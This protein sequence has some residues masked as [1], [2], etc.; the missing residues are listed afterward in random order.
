M[1]RPISAAEG[2]FIAGFI[3]GEGH[4]G[5]AEAE[6]RPVVPAASCRC[7]VRDDDAPLVEWLRDDD[8]ARHVACPSPRASTSKPQVRWLVRTQADCRALV[9]LLDRFELRGRKRARIRD[10]A[11][12]RRALARPGS[13]T[14][15]A[16]SAA[17]P[18]SVSRRPPLS[19]PARTSVVRAPSGSRRAQR[20]ICT[21]C[22]A[23]R[24][25]SAST[26]AHRRQRPSSTDDRPLLEMLARATRARLR[27][28][29]HRRIRR[30][31]RRRLARRAARRTS[32]DWRLARPGSDARPQG[33]RARVWLA[34]RRRSCDASARAAGRRANLDDLLAEFR[35]A[36]AYRPGRALAPADRSAS[37]ARERRWRSCAGGPH[38]SQGRC[39]AA[40][41]RVRSGDPTGRT[42][43][44]SH[45]DLAP[46]TRR[47]AA[48]GLADRAA[49]T[50]RAARGACARRRRGPR[51]RAEA[52]RERVLATLRYGVN[53]HGSLPTAMQ[54]FRWR[55]VE[56][57]ATPTQATVYR[58][59]PG[60]W[61]AVL[62]A[63][64]ASVDQPSRSRVAR[65]SFSTTRS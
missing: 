24:V 44:R 4:L 10:L 31:D 64:E 48:A 57:P 37:A 36:R 7:G 42:A 40:A 19:A 28:A 15:R 53:L 34:G 29:T 51:G 49:S 65:G 59:F 62:A 60:G 14:A 17:A 6:R 9:E 11:D 46:G 35:A 2:H 30:P 41:T 55:L 3:E 1:N 33:D 58:L 25:R 56:A 39:P 21:G 22:C 54:F 27:A 43:T 20:R 16:R 50:R 5:I 52:Q 18:S 12:A 23:R 61:P 8:R 32:L 63:Y 45:G 13:R 38:G 26:G 47:S